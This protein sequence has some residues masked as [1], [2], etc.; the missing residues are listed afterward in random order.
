[1]TSLS[2]DHNLNCCSGLSVAARH[3]LL[4]LYYSII[5]RK[6]NFATKSCAAYDVDTFYTKFHF[7]PQIAAFGENPQKGPKRPILGGPQKSV[8]IVADLSATPPVTL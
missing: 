7:V 3:L 4:S 1:M 2:S 5:D 6:Y 8:T